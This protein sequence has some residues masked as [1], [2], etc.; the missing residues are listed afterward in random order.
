MPIDGDFIKVINKGV[1]WLIRREYR[2]LLNDLL[3]DNF[4]RTDS[5][6]YHMIRTPPPRTVVSTF[7]NNIDQKE[8]VFIKIY[9]LS[10]FT[11]M[12]KYFFQKSKGRKEWEIGN[13]LLGQGIPTALPI[14]VGE[15][16]R[17]GILKEN[18]L[19]LKGIENGKSLK[20]YIVQGR[21]LAKKRNLPKILAVFI[22]EIHRK[23]ILHRDL[24]AG[25]I[26]V[27]EQ[28]KDIVKLY[29]ID[30]HDVDILNKLTISQILKNFAQINNPKARNTDRI[31]FIKEYT[32]DNDNLKH[33]Y[34]KYARIVGKLTDKRL[35]K[36]WQRRGKRCLKENK[37]FL[38]LKKDGFCGFLL[39]KYE[40]QYLENNLINPDIILNDSGSR[41][42]KNGRTTKSGIA[43]VNI[44]REIFIK[45]YNNKGL[46]YSLKNMFRKSRAI[47][48]WKVANGLIVRGIPTPRPIMV[49]VKRR[50]RILHESFLVSET[51]SGSCSL[52]LYLK[53]Q[54]FNDQES[55]KAF[56]LRLATFL[57]GLH[58][59]RGV[60]GDL[61][62]NNILVLRG[63]KN[64][65]FYFVDLDK[66]K[67]YKKFKA[68]N[69][70]RDLARLNADGI[71]LSI[72]KT[73]RFRF[74]K[75][76]LSFNRDMKEEKRKYLLKINKITHRHLRRHQKKE[77]Q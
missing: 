77:G 60:H 48:T 34:K 6:K 51:V 58:T 35:D 44:N 25:N 4:N 50:W 9:H 32:R 16:Y 73:D 69:A 20:H 17:L 75:F 21:G 14:A 54:P 12:I 2:D 26:I 72:N 55:K 64:I 27:Q 39:R 70:I 42:C 52:K 49:L 18:Y 40:K 76:Y 30:L 22:K 62:A 74:F 71:E 1:Y 36:L 13:E 24:H 68:D 67:I 33:P 19:I 8:K 47:K 5:N 38:F 41:I 43:R 56:Y 11:D 46:F 59:R 15:G 65:K 29:L 23:G 63:G 37:Y 3:N 53:Q 31:R 28:G 7:L 57:A 61:K 66:A 45:R 10:F